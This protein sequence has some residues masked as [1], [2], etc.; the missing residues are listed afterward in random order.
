MYAVYIHINYVYIYRYT[1]CVCDMNRG[2]VTTRRMS[3]ASC[4]CRRMMAVNGS[5]ALLLVIAMLCI[6]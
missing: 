3:A 6:C 2:M 1:N 4:T 5:L